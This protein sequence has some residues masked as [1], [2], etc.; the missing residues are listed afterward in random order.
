VV[1]SRRRLQWEEERNPN[2]IACR[3]MKIVVLII[4][5]VQYIDSTL[6]LMG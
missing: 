1:D 5:V 3:N 2:L 4:D 6:T